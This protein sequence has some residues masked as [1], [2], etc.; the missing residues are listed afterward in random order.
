MRVQWWLGRRLLR[1]QGQRWALAAVA[2]TSLLSG[3]LLLGLTSVPNVSAD[4]DRAEAARTIVDSVSATGVHATAS[5]W[6]W[7]GTQTIH[8]IRIGIEPKHSN[9]AATLPGVPR[10]PRPGEIWMSPQLVADIEDKA[11]L[12]RAFPQHR[13][14]TIAAVALP[15]ARDRVAYIGVEPASLS[16]LSQAAGQSIGA[17]AV[18][19][20]TGSGAVVFLAAATLLLFVGI[21]L[22]AL[23]VAC[24]LYTSPSPRD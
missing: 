16:G 6:D 3:L 24:L 9:S 5:T 13:A 11:D 20:R 10:P 18:E 2:L 22:G 21:P 4:R 12:G 1:A 14:G 7:Q 23:F 8:L 15:T 19:F 17:D